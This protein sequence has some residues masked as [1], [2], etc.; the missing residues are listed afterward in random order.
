MEDT[1]TVQ[2]TQSESL[3]EVEQITEDINKMNI[4]EKP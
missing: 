3:K 2:Q 4:E 1:Q